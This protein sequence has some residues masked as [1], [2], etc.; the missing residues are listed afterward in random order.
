MAHVITSLC[1]REGGCATV[2][3]VECIVPGKPANQYPGFYID[4]ETCIDCDACA[5]ECPYS[6]IYYD[7]E[8]PVA[9]T[10]KGGEIVSMPEGTPGFEDVYNGR[11]HDGEPVH[12]EATRKLAAGEVI[13]LTPAIEKNAEYFREGPGYTAA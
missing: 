4:P 13:D 3:P 9:F 5:P 6:A 7:T 11:N 12:M 2:C 10:A 1:L 8:V